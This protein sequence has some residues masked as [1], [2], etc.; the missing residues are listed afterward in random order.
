VEFSPKFSPEKMYEKLA[1]ADFL[2][3][4]FRGKFLGISWKNDFSKLFPRKIPFF[5]NIFWEKIFRGI[6]PK[7]FPEKMY[8]KLAPMPYLL[9]DKTPK[10]MGFGHISTY[11]YLSSQ[12]RRFFII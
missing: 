12:I 1:R 8:K 3:I 5:P 6:F 10:K 7:I 9:R 4:F 11:I 2:Y